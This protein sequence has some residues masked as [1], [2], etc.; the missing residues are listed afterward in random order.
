MRDSTLES[1][2][3]R[4]CR[5]KHGPIPGRAHEVSQKRS[6]SRVGLGCNLAMEM[7]M[8]VRGGEQTEQSATTAAVGITHWATEFERVYLMTAARI[9]GK[10]L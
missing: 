9:R 1:W 8:S 2:A 5:P 6:R 4:S 7:T 10:P 3:R